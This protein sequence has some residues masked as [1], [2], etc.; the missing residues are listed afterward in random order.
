MG[1]RRQRPIGV[2]IGSRMIHA[3]QLNDRGAPMHRV[4]MARAHPGGPFD[5]DEALRLA[6]VLIR[7][8]IPGDR[9]VLAAPPD[10]TLNAS[11]ELPPRSSGAPLEQIARAESARM[12]NV[13]D[14]EMAFW[15]IP[16]PARAAS[17]SYGI[18]T[19]CPHERAENLLAAFDS[20]PFIP[21]AIDLPAWAFARAAAPR[22][23]PGNVS[24]V[25]DLGWSR[26][27][28]IALHG[29]TVIVQRPLPEA[30]VHSAHGA[31]LRELDLDAELAEIITEQIGFDGEIEGAEPGAMQIVRDAL[32]AHAE[33]TIAEVRS[34]LSYVSH[35]YPDARLSGVLLV[36]GGAAMPGLRG[37][38]AAAL[39][40]PVETLTPA[41]L[42]PCP[43]AVAW[44]DPGLTLA[45]GV[46]R[47]SYAA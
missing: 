29:E 46:A 32:T 18:A 11:L 13:T 23:D 19:I 27:E 41:T 38:I 3:V 44:D 47:W 5:A 42:A 1:W 28:L 22:L 43:D 34:S 14:F 8:N 24:A 33:R 40:C 30:G 26:G 17:A 35:R 6:E 10:L 39:P 31:L 20:T 2:D 16:E 25:L 9:L 21:E 7:R 15:S 4:A 12:H 36:G 37:R 45:Y